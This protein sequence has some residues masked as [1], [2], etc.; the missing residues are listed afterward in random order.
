MNKQK[1]IINTIKN[2]NIEFIKIK[3]QI[4]RM[5]V[6]NF[7]IKMVNKLQGLKNEA[8]IKKRGFIFFS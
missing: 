4:N 6:Y 7:P 2:I 8:T 3:K 5:F 1:F